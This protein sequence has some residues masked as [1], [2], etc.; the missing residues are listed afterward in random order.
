[1]ILRHHTELTRALSRVCLQLYCM[2]HSQSGWKRNSIQIKLAAQPLTENQQLS[3]TPPVLHCFQDISQVLLTS[4]TLCATACTPHYSGD[5]GHAAPPGKPTCPSR[6]ELPGL[7]GPSTLCIHN[8]RI[9]RP[10]ITPSHCF[11]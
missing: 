7:Q 5:K 6:E 10:K 9:E 3:G 11:S 1:M 8:A 4:V 2:A